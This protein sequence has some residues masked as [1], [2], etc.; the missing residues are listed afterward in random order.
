MSD[1]IYLSYF[2][3]DSLTAYG[4]GKRIVVEKSKSI[5]NGDS[6][7]NSV[8]SF[9][10]HLGTHI[11]YQFHFCKDGKKSSDYTVNDHIFNNVVVVEI[12]LVNS[13]ILLINEDILPLESL[14]TEIDCLIIKTGFSNIRYEDR[15]WNFNPGINPN[16]AEKLN[17]KF[18][19]LRAIGFD[20]ISLSSY[21]H[22]DI[23]REAHKEFLCKYGY[24]IVEDMDLT[25]IYSKSKIKRLIIAPILIKN[26]DG[27]PVTVIAEVNNND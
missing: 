11:D 16:L 24:L 26:I 8:L 2:L 7:N 9:S 14:N 25:K 12:D 3:S 6:S 15:Y 17:K 27:V 18:P 22:R 13:D 4:N 1:F 21:Q 20:S 5:I 19:K 23:G 10:S